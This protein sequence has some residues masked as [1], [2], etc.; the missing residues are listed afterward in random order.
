MA[1]ISIITRTIDRPR[2][3]ARTLDSLLAQTFADWE[4]VIV[5]GGTEEGLE[6]SLG[7]RRAQL[8]ERVKVHRFQNPR[9]GMRG[10]PINE[11][12]RHSSSP[13][14]TVLDDDDTWEPDFLDTMIRGLDAAPADVGGI[15]CQTQI[16]EE[17][18]VEEGLN[19]QRTYPL[20]DDLQN[21]TLA[22]VAVVNAF[23]IHAF[24]YRREVFDAIGGYSEALPV[25]EDWDFN[26]RF[27]C[28]S[29]L[30]VIPRILTHYHL[31]PAVKSG[32]E[33]N[34]QNAEFDLHK[35]YESRIINAA[36]RD[37]SNPVLGQAM[38]SAAHTRWLERRIHSV[39]SKLKSAADKIGKIDSRT[40]ELKDR[41]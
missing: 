39:E 12:V 8:G 27:L 5:N 34:S 15:V 29:D 25:L 20:N 24:V 17:S 35:F 32:H 1:R 6:A 33:A 4:L 36:M 3:L 19:V 14:I 26:L 9:P 10:V 18:S 41:R 21:V 31:R 7:P 37:A 11:G 2:L 16:I 38:A 22:R 28:H 13:L 30:V 40:K 23:C